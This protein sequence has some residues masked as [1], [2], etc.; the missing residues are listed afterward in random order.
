MV[1]EYARSRILKRLH[2]LT[3]GRIAGLRTFEQN[4]VRSSCL[5]G[6]W[7]RA[8]CSSK[9]RVELKG[10]EIR[11]QLIINFR[12][13]NRMGFIGAD[14]RWKSK[15]GALVSTFIRKT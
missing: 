5:V 15:V 10:T 13:A 7:R 2:A 12:S 11:F 1:N 14:I 4:Q 8:R 3:Q 9:L 6:E